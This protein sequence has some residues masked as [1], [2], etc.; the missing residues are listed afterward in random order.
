MQCEGS[1]VTYL[2]NAIKLYDDKSYFEGA[3]IK[4]FLK[5]NLEIW[6]FDQL[7][8]L[9][10][11]FAM[12][13]SKSARDALYLKY[14]VLYAFLSRKRK[15]GSYCTERDSFEWLCVRLTSLDGFQAFKTIVE[16]IGEFYI[17][18]KKTNAFL[19]DWF[20]SNAQNKFGKKRI[21]N[22][23]IENAKKSKAVAAFLH[24]VD[25]FDATEPQNITQP[26]LKELVEACSEP[27]GYRGRGIA[28]RF[29][30][31]ASIEELTEL[32]KIA[33]TETNLEIKLGLLWV[34]R[35]KPFPLDESFIFELAESDNEYIRDIAFEIMQHLSSEMIHDYTIKLIKEKKEIE[36]SLS[37]LCYCYKP[38]DEKLLAEGVKGL[39]VSYDDGGWHGVFMDVEGLLDKRSCRFEADLFIHIYP[40]TLCSSCR[41]R[42][43]QSMYKRKILPDEIL[44]ECLYDSY[45]DTRKFAVRKLKTKGH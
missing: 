15:F 40:Q 18:T 45:E 4:K 33:V 5:K 6:L 1:R 42:L 22:Y 13:G 12:D 38:D 34:F 36:N 26:T 16:Q 10:F 41:S 3:I 9:L 44:E 21:D 31:V 28:N 39:F 20:Y 37:L 11:Q 2:Y 14:D 24:E 19:M 25:S 7:C 32:A 35:K 8:D 29:A 17:S 30:R 43:V 27:S 23:M